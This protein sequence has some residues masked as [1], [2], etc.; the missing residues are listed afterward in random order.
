M[1][2]KGWNIDAEKLPCWDNRETILDCRDYL[3][4]SPTGDAACL[5]YSVAEVSMLKYWGFCAIYKNRQAPELALCVRYVNFAPYARFSR[6]GNLVFLKATYRAGVR[7]ILILDLKKEVY[8]TVKFMPHNMEYDIR[9]GDSGV[10]YTV[11][12]PCAIEND[13]CLAKLFHGTKIDPARLRWRKWS[14]LSDG[15]DLHLQERGPRH[16]FKCKETIWRESKDKLRLGAISA[17]E[18]VDVNRDKVL[19]HFSPFKTDEYGH[20]RASLLKYIEFEGCYLPVFSTRESCVDF[21]ECRG[22]RRVIYKTRLKKLMQVMD[23]HYPMRDW[24]IVIDPHHE[25]WIAIPNTV[26]VTPK[27]LRY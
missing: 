25:D 11:F 6:D 3:Y 16:F 13:V 22:E 20:T 18:F 15:G 4:E 21:L 23:A 9:E 19:Y 12:D 17:Q 7:F 2:L 14:A 24:G 10:F 5:I 1:E 26:R 8:A 27:S